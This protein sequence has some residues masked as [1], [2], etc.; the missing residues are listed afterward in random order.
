MAELEL[1]V[2]AD[3]FVFLEGPRWHQGR[4]WFSDMWGHAVHAMSEDGVCERIAE[5]PNRPSGLCFLPDGRLVVVSMADRRLLLVGADGSV[6]EYA[7]LSALASGD[8][9]DSICDRHG[10]IY[11]GNFGYDLFSGAEP[12]LADLVRVAPDGS[13]SVAATGLNFPN[14]TVITPD[15]RTMICAE[16]FGHCL[17]AFDLSA[18]GQLSGRRVWAEL[19][20]RTPD[21]ICLD[22]AG[23]VWIAS[24]MTGEFVRVEE[25]GQVTDIAPCPGK[26]AVACNLG[27][28]EGKTLFALTYE[29][30]LEDIQS[31][32]RNARI[33]TCQVAVASAG[34]P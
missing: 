5:V 4:L 7:D 28:A 25:G 1:K 27:G 3:G 12:A 13:T 30:E 14:G 10:N 8:T 32:A 17:T 23:G 31:G 24:F 2:L 26:C 9:N 34:S 16:T 29:G 19:G 11:V 21:G 6:S 18:D 33:E 22:A 20:E 15:G